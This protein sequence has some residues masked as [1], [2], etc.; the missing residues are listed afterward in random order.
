MTF[1]L[2]AKL[3]LPV[4]WT[5]LDFMEFDYSRYFEEK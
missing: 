2:V 1:K 4:R 3:K 5:A